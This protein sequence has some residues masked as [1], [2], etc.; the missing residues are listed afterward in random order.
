M[1][2]PA[3]ILVHS[4]ATL[5]SQLKEPAIED[6]QVEDVPSGIQFER[7][8]DA[9]CPLVQ[10]SNQQTTEGD[11]KLAHAEV[12]ASQPPNVS[13]ARRI[14]H[15]ETASIRPEA[16]IRVPEVDA[17]ATI[18]HLVCP[19]VDPLMDRSPA[20]AT[21]AI[22]VPVQGDEPD[23]IS[24][25]AISIS[26]LREQQ[27]ALKRE[28]SKQ[29]ALARQLSSAKRETERRLQVLTRY[30]DPTGQ[31]EEPSTGV[32]YGHR[33]PEPQ[34]PQ[35]LHHHQQHHHR[36]HP[37]CHTHRQVP[38]QQQ[39]PHHHQYHRHYQQHQEQ[40]QKQA[41]DEGVQLHA[42]RS[43]HR[44]KSFDRPVTDSP[45]D[46][47]AERRTASMKDQMGPHLECKDEEEEAFDDE[48]KAYS[49]RNKAFKRAGKDQNETR[50]SEKLE[51]R[52]VNEKEK[53]DRDKLS[54]DEAEP[55]NSKHLDRKKKKEKEKKKKKKE[56]SN[57]FHER[58]AGESADGPVDDA[59]DSGNRTGHHKIRPH[60]TRLP[61]EDVGPQ[62]TIVPESRLS[63]STF[64]P[65]SGRPD[66]ATRRLDSA[67]GA[68]AEVP[69][70]TIKPFT[71]P[72]PPPTQLPEHQI[73]FADSPAF[74]MTSPPPPPPLSAIIWGSKIE[75]TSPQL[76]TLPPALLQTPP[77]CASPLQ[78]A[79]EA[80]Q[81]PPL[82]TDVSSSPLVL[83]P[84]PPPPPPPPLS[85]SQ[86]T[87][88]PSPSPPHSPPSSVPPPPPLPPPP[89]IS[90]KPNVQKTALCLQAARLPVF[91]TADPTT[92]G[93]NSLQPE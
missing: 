59:T 53:E 78:L 67:S 91:E 10:P 31:F 40:N 1:L 85:S 17:T 68:S 62:P 2:K 26:R 9:D 35:C 12:A 93:A 8:T 60:R 81:P 64:P 21:I 11:S 30:E 77:I 39:K 29:R 7:L 14:D 36:P 3:E 54:A 16:H 92:G 20:G 65:A 89:P 86:L 84:A 63:E 66:R 46:R 55:R 18:V 37:D 49:K 70:T 79:A 48:E 44:N 69:G 52:H 13:R 56:S 45:G 32:V 74:S 71:L 4:Q 83:P 15:L 5:S 58:R 73:R 61:H 42:R 28:L 43:S 50:K 33:P 27:K 57:D 38:L 72:T 87:L 22:T 41:G 47:T 76:A 23:D 88:P 75:L 90:Q 82:P 25:T 51:E 24:S 80:G 19:N 6:R 34:Q